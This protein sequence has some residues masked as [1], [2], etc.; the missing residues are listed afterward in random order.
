[1][2]NFDNK[3]I[4]KNYQT[5]T[6]IDPTEPYE[7]EFLFQILQLFSC[8]PEI[9]NEKGGDLRVIDNNIQYIDWAVFP[10]YS[11]W[12]KLLFDKSYYSTDNE[13]TWV[14]SDALA[15][16]K[17]QLSNIYNFF[18]YNTDKE[19]LDEYKEIYEPYIYNLFSLYSQYVYSSEFTDLT[20]F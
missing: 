3:S 20:I 4:F 2:L 19:T 11:A 13:E 7:Q 12:I 14:Y 17:N 1:M 8:V 15:P 9:T 10:K 18:G 5:S 6:Y 16:H